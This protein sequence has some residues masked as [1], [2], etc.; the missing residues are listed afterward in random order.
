MKGAPLKLE[1]LPDVLEVSE[2]ARVLR[3]SREKVYQEIREGR[4]KHVKFGRRKVV[5]KRYVLE[6]LEGAAAD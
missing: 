4:L 1:E 5:P 6:L 3:I 2:V